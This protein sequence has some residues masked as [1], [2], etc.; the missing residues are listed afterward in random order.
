MSDSN[1]VISNQYKLNKIL[2]AMAAGGPEKLHILADFDKTLT[3]A[4][5]NGSRY[6]SVISQIRDGAYLPEEYNKAAHELFGIYSV[7]ERD[8]K[9][10]IT[11][12]QAKMKEWWDE[13]HKLLIHYGLTKNILRDVVEHKTLILRDGLKELFN[14]LDH[15]QIPL[16]IM[17]AAPGDLIQMH[18]EDAGLMTDNIYIIANFY[19]FNSVG[20]MT[21]V[22]DPI[23]HSL[24]KYETTVESFPV[25]QKI[26]NR[27]NVILLGDG[28]D[29]I[30]MI[31]GFACDNLIKIGFLNEKAEENLTLYKENFDVIIINDVD[32][33][34]V[35]KLIQKITFEI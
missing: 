34:Y 14:Q 9:I 8:I 15:F 4:F 33:Y 12:R 32:I 1:I 11:N 20:R 23:I 16:V 13:H 21:G 28:I 7:F 17:S 35:Q 30:G 29:D 25:F 10:P 3:K 22:K 6:H 31:E 26:K 24:N 27:K 19:E 5:T 18:L 2:D